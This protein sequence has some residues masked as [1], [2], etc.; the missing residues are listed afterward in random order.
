MPKHRKPK[1]PSRFPPKPPQPT[2]PPSSPGA[3][4]RFQP[5]P[6]TRIFPKP[7]GLPRPPSIPLLP[8]G[9]GN[10]GKVAGGF[11]FPTGAVGRGAGLVGRR[12]PYVALGFLAFDAFLIACAAGLLPGSICPRPDNPSPGGKPA[13]FSGGQCPIYYSF[14]YRNTS[15]DLV[16][17]KTE[18]VGCKGPIKFIYTE[19]QNTG[20]SAP[21]DKAWYIIVG[22]EEPDDMQVIS[23]K[24]FRTSM[25]YTNYGRAQFIGIET[26]NPFNSNDVPLDNCGDLPPS[27]A[28]QRMPDPIFNITNINN[29]INL[30]ITIPRPNPPS[31]LPR[32]N[33][34]T[35]SPP[36]PLPDLN[37]DINSDFPPEVVNV[38]DENNN[39]FPPI[40]FNPQPGGNFNDPPDGF[41]NFPP[42]P[43][44]DLR[45]P[46]PGPGNTLIAGP[47]P[48][49][50]SMPQ[51][52]P[53]IPDTLPDDASDSDRYQFR[54]NR[55]IL[56]KLYRANNEI[57]EIQTAI[58]RQNQILE[59]LQRLLDIE[60]SGSQIIE[61]CDGVDIVYS[62][63]DKILPAISRQL[64]HV[65]AIEQTIINEICNVEKE[66]IVAI[67]EWW[68]VR[69]RPDVPQIALIFRV[70]KSRTYHKLTI[71]HPLNTSQLRLPPIPTYKK[72]N[73]QG[74]LVCI[75]NSK[76]I[77]NCESKEEAERVLSIAASL[78]NPVF[79]GN[80][81]RAYLAER[82]GVAVGP[83]DMFATSAL[84]FPLGQ[85]QT[86]PEWRAVFTSFGI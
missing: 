84:Y 14:I 18:G 1:P 79:L 29:N 21:F 7:I 61:R 40:S 2:P 53:P 20:N 6:P 80:P 12:I 23:P 50:P 39:Y 35:P 47:A 68:Q 62:Y 15:G 60:A 37:F 38:G 36:Q 42:R 56:D 10:A 13:D 30:N 64:N 49:L 67:P 5:P 25:G 52:P 51:I 46:G 32:Q 11:K 8:P 26:Y 43:Q 44:P 78:I 82:K 72:G 19:I 48:S 45:Y 86:R 76:F 28:P 33:R 81:Y 66:S 71:P 16:R 85:Q 74:E 27:P 70:G 24:V 73:W 57:L 75:D 54:Q 69:L 65:K 77:C 63:Q 41:N 31:P 55:E 83:G 17:S 22:A 9:V 58:A 34:L 4:I 59:N 3:L